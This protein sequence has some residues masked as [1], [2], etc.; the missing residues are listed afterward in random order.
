M[1]PQRQLNARSGKEFRDPKSYAQAWYLSHFCSENDVQFSRI[2]RKEPP[3]TPRR[4]KGSQRE[5]GAPRAP[6]EGQKE[7]NGVPEGGKGGPWRPK[8]SSKEAHIHKNSRSTAPSGQ[9]IQ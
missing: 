1:V 5:L 8:G 7:P 6:K 2:S 4:P 3:G 9:Y